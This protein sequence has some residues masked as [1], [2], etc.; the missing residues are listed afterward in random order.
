MMYLSA[1]ILAGGRGK[2]FG[3]AKAFAELPD[4]SSFLQTCARCLQ[5]ADCSPILATLPEGMGGDRLPSGIFS[6]EVNHDLD[7]FASICAGI[8]GL[9]GFSDW[10]KLLILPVDHPLI[11]PATCRTLGSSKAEAA[12]PSYQGRHGHPIMISRKICRDIVR[13][14]LPGPTL[15]EVLKSAGA[16]DVGVD[17]P[18]IRANCNTVERLAEALSEIRR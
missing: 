13:G 4:G 16:V 11:L 17:D 10:K 5:D 2:R 3:R 7:M 9:L 15:R 14:I 12:I 18:G 6:R 1:L 8:E